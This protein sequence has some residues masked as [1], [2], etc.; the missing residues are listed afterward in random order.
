M[1]DSGTLKWP[2]GGAVSRCCS[3]SV[4]PIA[5]RKRSKFP[6]CCAVVLVT[7]RHLL[8]A[9]PF[10][11]ICAF[12]RASHRDGFAHRMRADAKKPCMRVMLLHT[13]YQSFLRRFYRDDAGLAELSYDEQLKR[14][15]DSLF[16]LSDF[17]SN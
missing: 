3:N 12:C 16:S 13:D 8:N 5:K 4:S 7:P 15:N 9:P 17:Y 6:H 11:R 2:P 10:W 1:D 14:R